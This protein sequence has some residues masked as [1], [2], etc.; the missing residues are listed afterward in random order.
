[1]ALISYLVARC[2]WL[3]ALPEPA[4]NPG[5]CKSLPPLEFL[6][7]N[8]K[9]YNYKCIDILDM[10]TFNIRKIT[11]VVWLPETIRHGHQDTEN[12][13]VENLSLLVNY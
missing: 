6:N 1:M 11:S 10:C 4:Y 9:S 13:I 8:Y 3:V 5:P 7:W 2:S 12:H